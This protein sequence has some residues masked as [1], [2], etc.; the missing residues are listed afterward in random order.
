MNLEISDALL[1]SVVRVGKMGACDR[2][3]IIGA[4]EQ[5]K[6]RPLKKKLIY[7]VSTPHVAASLEGQ[8]Y[9]VVVLPSYTAARTDRLKAA[10]V[11]AV[12]S[13]QLKKGENVVCAMCR[14]EGEPI[15][16]VMHLT[17]SD[18]QEEHSS[19]VVTSLKSSVDP[20]LLEV[21]VN[22]AL[23]IGREGYEGRALGTL[24]VVGD[25]TRVMEKSHPLTLNPFQGY[26]EAE[27][28]LFDAHVRDAVRTFAML[29]G[30]FVVR[31]DGVV[32]AA[33]RHIR[34]GETPPEL[35]LGMGTRHVAAASVSKDTGAIALAVS[36]SS[37]D[38]R[39]FHDG[40][41]VLEISPGG[42]RVDVNT[43]ASGEKTEIVVK[44]RPRPKKAHPRPKAKPRPN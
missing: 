15:D 16:T 37:G 31:D 23:R 12:S 38:V 34:V 40:E 33:G 5:E 13:G 43:D 4:E 1:D 17:A 39:I 22:L 28:N 9:D 36:Q 3:L 19:L 27:R 10:L 7:A 26:S 29:D 21:V 25:S 24:I 8:G 41:L 6:L 35:P 42:R 32:L 30:A 18:E 14:E 11:G 20:Q 2:I 44:K